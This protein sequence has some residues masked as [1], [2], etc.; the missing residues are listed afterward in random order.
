MGNYN[1]AKKSRGLGLKKSNF[2]N[3]VFMEKLQW[4]LKNDYNKPWIKLFNQKY[5]DTIIYKRSSFIY[6]S[7]RKGKQIY[8][9][10]FS[11]LIKNGPNVDL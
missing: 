10:N 8:S 4:E 6:K 5:K 9:N 2:V 7:I 3:V 1:K 11:Y